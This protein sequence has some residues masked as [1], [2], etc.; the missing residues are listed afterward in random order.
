MIG[1]I[2]HYSKCED[3]SYTPCTVSQCLSWLS[4]QKEYQLDIETDGSNGTEWGNQH[5]I[6]VQFGSTTGPD[7]QWFLQWSE[8][9]DGEKAQLKEILERPF[10]LKL[11]HNA[12]FE[13][14]VFRFHG[15]RITNWW[16]TMLAD[17]VLTGGLETQEYGLADISYKYLRIFMDKSLQTSFGDN[18]ITHAKLTYAVTDVAY[19]ATIKRMQMQTMEENNLSRVMALEM[20]ALPAFSEITYN[21]MRLDQEKWREN[22]KLAEPVIQAAY[23]KM[24][25]W[26]THESFAFM[27]YDL[28]YI[29]DSDRVE[30]N[31][32]SWHQ[33]SQLLMEHFGDRVDGEGVFH[34]GIAGGTKTI[35]KA[36][37]SKMGRILSQEDMWALVSF[38][39]GKTEEFQTLMLTHHREWLIEQGFLI[40][41]GQSTI[42]W[43]SGD[44]VLPLMKCV[45]P[46]LKGLSADDVAKTRHPA[47]RD[48][49]A[50]REAL[51]LTTTYGERFIREHVNQDGNVR[52]N[53]NQIMSTG[54]ISNYS[55]N[56]QNVVVT[57]L[58]GT[59]YRNAFVID[60][61][62]DVFVD[63]DYVSQELTIIAYV[64]QDP[65]WLECLRKG[66][67]LH[68][69][70]AELIYKK[71][72]K[73]AASPGCQYYEHGHQKCSCKGHKKMRSSI[74]AINFGLAYGMTEY[75]LS[76][77]L[78]IS[79]AEALALINEYFRTFPKIRA[80]L[81]FYGKFGLQRGY[82]QT[83]APFFRKRWFPN[84]YENRAFVDGH[85]LGIKP[86]SA[87]G[88][89]ERASKNM[90]IQGSSADIVKVAMIMVYNYIF[91]NG[92]GEDIRIRAQVHDQITTTCQEGTSSWW[93]VTLNLLMEG[94]AK[95]VIPSGLLKAE[96]NISSCW[97]K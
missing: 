62:G 75:K 20:E 45:E 51:K 3:S 16:D 39:E 42:N 74:K 1:Q 61:P 38:Q 57:E 5:I 77:E 25:T 26:L 97:T 12:R 32:K 19:L 29:S 64:S 56:L 69:V 73:D 21:G 50:Y 78:G 93:K 53:I 15:I 8:L 31:W 72:W 88:E 79:L 96:T 41:A 44:Q 55:P 10:P 80:R 27:A 11:A 6:S 43:N 34:P 17:K 23:D 86:V 71:K 18:T 85:L 68:S 52:A 58:V 36:Y 37:I 81:E 83:L 67:D 47:L 70:C 92:Y 90:P 76:G 91:D 14:I 35:V 22:I 84:W 66:E 95:V 13:Y 49:Q 94:A 59:R 2:F 24:N 7:T 54:R 30:I 28:G 4:V 9:S 63:S 65:V 60:R 40:P 87:L 33:K 82:I 48:L 46:K 89:I